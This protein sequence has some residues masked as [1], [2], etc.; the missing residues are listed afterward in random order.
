MKMCLDGW[1]G[2]DEDIDLTKASQSFVA[3]R[4]WVM[5]LSPVIT[6]K[7]GQLGSMT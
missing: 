5:M 4:R 6:F 3:T 2:L 7:P 1:R